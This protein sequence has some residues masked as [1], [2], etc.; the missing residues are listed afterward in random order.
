MSDVVLPYRHRFSGRVRVGQDF[1]ELPGAA[2]SFKAECDINRI[3]AKFQKTGMVEW[4][5]RRQPEYLDCSGEDFQD[6]MFTV[7]KAREM[8]AELPSSM[9]DRFA[10]DPQKLLV[11]LTKEE[12]RAEA[13]SLG[14]VR[15]PDAPIA[16]IKVEVVPPKA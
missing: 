12:N 13:I 7:V 10:N 16:P 5:S 1:S 8:F 11:F 3:M 4:L 6:A 14:L 2:Q 15:R 9:R